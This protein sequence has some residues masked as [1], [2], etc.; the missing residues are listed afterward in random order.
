MDPDPEDVPL[1]QIEH[2]S[3][4]GML[5]FGLAVPAG[6]GLQFSSPGAASAVEYVPAR[7]ARQDELE[8]EPVSLFHRPRLHEVHEA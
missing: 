2:V 8:V 6:H 1:P 4:L 3:L 5:A 7:Q